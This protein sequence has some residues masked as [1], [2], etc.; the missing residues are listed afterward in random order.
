MKKKLS[1]AI[2]DQLINSGSSFL[3]TILLARSLSEEFLGIYFSFNLFYLLCQSIQHSVISAPAYSL[4]PRIGDSSTKSLYSKY[5]I[6]RQIAL[7][8]LFISAY[9]VICLLSSTS[10]A[11]RSLS[12]ITYVNYGLV[13]YALSFF[14]FQRKWMIANRLYSNLVIFSS[15]RYFAQLTIA[16]LLIAFNYF[17]LNRLAILLVFASLAPLIILNPMKLGQRKLSFKP[18]H[19][20]D[21]NII[22]NHRKISFDL[23]PAAIMQWTSGG[24]YELQALKLLGP[25]I[26]AVIKVVQSFVSPLNLLNQI[27]ENWLVV[28]FAPRYSSGK[29]SISRVIN[30]KLLAFLVLALLFLVYIVNLSSSYIL[31]F[32]YGQEYF[33][34]GFLIT[35]Y[36]IVM[37]LVVLNTSLRSYLTAKLSTSVIKFAYATSTLF[38]LVVSYYIVDNF[39]LN[40]VILGGV[41]SQVIL[42][43]V[44]ISS[45]FISR[46]K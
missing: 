18:N 43:I 1:L 42:T 7:G 2:S 17:S 20:L 38:A 31:S 22:I 39:R 29:L 13:L 44:M 26:F 14:D 3:F 34:Y 21:K 5:L 28:L 19:I 11:P 41:L 12:Y 23:L 10:L 24:I 36:F 16:F 40:G 27:A 33:K 30:F 8:L 32:I 46:H 6:K 45:F 25:S 15:I 9:I 37:I 35:G 4:V